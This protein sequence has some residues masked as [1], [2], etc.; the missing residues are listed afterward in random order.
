MPVPNPSSSPRLPRLPRL[1]IAHQLSLLIAAAV[2]LAVLSVGALSVWN[3]H[4]GFLDYLQLRDE[5]QLMRLTKLVEQRAAADPS[6]D[7]L[8]GNREAMRA[9]MDEFNGS[10]GRSRPPGPPPRFDR[11]P[12]SPSDP[13]R[14]QPQRPPPPR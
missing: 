4:S 11:P 8:R 5:D 6:M 9:L 2:A 10:Q 14:P 7:W 12:P 13:G 3:L 1:R